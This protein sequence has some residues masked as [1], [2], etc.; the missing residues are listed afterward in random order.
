[1]KTKFTN[2]CLHGG[3]AY[4]LSDGVLECI[5]ISSGRRVW[6]RGRFGHGQLL[7]VDDLLLVQA[8]SGEIVLVEANSQRF[9][10]LGSIPALEGQTWN[11]L[12]LYKNRLLARNAR[13]ATCFSLTIQP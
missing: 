5:E 1:M 3:Y 6:K 7:R 10:Q 11:N 9:Q 8:E 2:A 4:G 13:E 12:C